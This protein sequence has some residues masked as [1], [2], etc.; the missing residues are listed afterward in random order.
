MNARYTPLK[1]FHDLAKLKVDNHSFCVRSSFFTA[2]T[3]QRAP[4]EH[5]NN[6]IASTKLLLLVLFA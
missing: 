3:K 6:N 4:R 1:T 5:E 2:Y